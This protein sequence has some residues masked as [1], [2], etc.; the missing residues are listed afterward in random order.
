MK[1]AQGLLDC[2]RLGTGSPREG[3]NASLENVVNFHCKTSI[4]LVSENDCRSQWHED[5]RSPIQVNAFSRPQRKL[6]LPTGNQ[7]DSATDDSG[8]LTERSC[9]VGPEPCYVGK[10]EGGG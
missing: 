2:I 10:P 8:L 3:G 7:V 1:L 6:P 4:L 9:Y 5:E